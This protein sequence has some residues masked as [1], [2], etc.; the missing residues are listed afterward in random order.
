MCVYMRYKTKHEEQSS[1]VFERAQKNSNFLIINSI[2]GKLLQI[3]IGSQRHIIF[4]H[5][6]LIFDISTIDMLIDM[7]PNPEK[8]KNQI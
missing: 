7:L 6:I 3:F 8:A 4:T 2:I 1:D 5:I